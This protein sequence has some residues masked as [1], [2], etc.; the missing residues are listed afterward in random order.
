MW[1]G[2][3]GYSSAALPY[4]KPRYLYGSLGGPKGPSGW[5]RETSQ[6]RDSFPGR[7]SPYRVAVLTELHRS[8]QVSGCF[9]K[10]GLC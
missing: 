1:V 2:G 3:Q 6:H 7:C 8:T 9:I 5:E 10:Y 4:G